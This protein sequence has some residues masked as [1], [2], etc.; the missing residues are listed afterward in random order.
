MAKSYLLHLLDALAVDLAPDR[1]LR[2]DLDGLIRVSPVPLLGGHILCVVVLRLLATLIA[3]DFERGVE[4]ILTDCAWLLLY[5]GR[6]FP[7]RKGTESIWLLDLHVAVLSVV[8]DKLAVLRDL[9]VLRLPSGWVLLWVVVG[10]EADGR[11]SDR[12]VEV[13]SVLR[14]C[15]CP[16][17]LL[18]DEV[19]KVAA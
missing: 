10:A 8:L 13:E 18:S 4:Q 12:V 9:S 1:R 11:R 2:H 5:R 14:L 3:V 15:Y 19:C 17:L 16:V 7:Y 6:L